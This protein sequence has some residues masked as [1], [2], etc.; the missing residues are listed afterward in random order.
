[1]KI[2]VV[3]DAHNAQGLADIDKVRKERI[4]QIERHMKHVSQEVRD[5]VHFVGFVPQVRA[6]EDLTTLISYKQL[7]E[8]LSGK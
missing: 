1:M 6:T 4:E 7:K 5:L 3:L 8:Q 2:L